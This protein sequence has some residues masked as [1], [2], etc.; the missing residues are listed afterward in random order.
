MTYEYDYLGN[1]TSETDA[2]GAVSTWTYNHLNQVLDA[3]HPLG[4]ID[5]SVYDRAG[6]LVWNHQIGTDGDT[7]STRYHYGLNNQVAH[8]YSP[9]NGVT[10]FYY[11]VER[12][13]DGCGTTGTCSA[14]GT[15]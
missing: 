7:R 15:Q 4:R 13:P 1:R 6:R 2:A 14:F 11:V 5:R 8:I 3:T 9:L 12:V 10:T